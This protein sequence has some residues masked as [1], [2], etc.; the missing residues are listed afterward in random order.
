MAR[1]VIQ[2]AQPP[3]RQVTRRNSQTDWFLVEDALHAQCRPA[4]EIGGAHFG[5]R[6]QLLA[7]AASS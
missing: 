7:G 4:F 6:Q 1:P 5:S 2:A 3:R